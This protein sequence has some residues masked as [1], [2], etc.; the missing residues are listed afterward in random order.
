MS[1]SAQARYALDAYRKLPVTFVRRVLFG[2]DPYFRRFFWSRWGVP[3]SDVRR[4]LAGH[5]VIWLDAISGGEVTQSVTFCRTLRQR[6]P[7]HRLLLVTN[8]KYSYDFAKGSLD[9]HAVMDSPWDCRGPVRRALRAIAPVAIVAIE[10]LAAPVLFAEAHRRAI[11]TVVV[12]GLMSH[13]FERHPMMTRPLE[14]R[15]FDRVDWIGAKGDEDVAGFVRMGARPGRVVAT[16]NMKFDLDYLHVSDAERA[17]IAADMGLDGPGERVFLAASIHPREEQLVGAAYRTARARVPSLRLVIVPRYQTHVDDMMTSL[18]A[19]GISSVRRTSGARPGPGDALIVDTFGELSR[20]Y[21]IAAVT[22]VGGSTYLR[23]AAGLGQ[24]IV[25][26]LAQ[27]Q[28]IF[29]GPHMNLWREI[30]EELKKTWP[31]VEVGDEEAL[32][33]GLTTVL[34][35]ARLAERLTVAA[36]AIMA[37]HANDVASNVDLVVRAVTSSGGVR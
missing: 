4:A 26:P 19:L 13:G 27:A 2:R 22:F 37:R 32:T 28:P 29:F 36:R 20:L 33:R 21:A 35:D 16:G 5:P 12:S 6:L 11:A 30:T 8:N 15:P 24:N 23:N 34:T 7:D 10:N 25:E 17:R 31:F 3:A 14:Q 9:V 18:R 1:R